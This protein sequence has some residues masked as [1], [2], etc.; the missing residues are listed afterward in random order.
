M[1]L[2]SYYQARIRQRRTFRRVN[3]RNA[4]SHKWIPRKLECSACGF[5][6][7]VWVGQKKRR[8]PRCKVVFMYELA[9]RG[10]E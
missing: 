6:T 2:E 7:S 5:K 4:R 3:H 9:S 1:R 10:K 8:I